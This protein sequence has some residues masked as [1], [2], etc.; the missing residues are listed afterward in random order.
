MTGKFKRAPRAAASRQ[1]CAAARH[2]QA[3]TCS[4]A[5]ERMARKECH[6]PASGFALFRNG[7]EACPFRAAPMTHMKEEASCFWRACYFQAVIKRLSEIREFETIWRSCHRDSPRH[8]CCFPE[9]Y[10]KIARC[11]GKKFV[12]E[13]TGRLGKTLRG[14]R[15]PLLLAHRRRPLASVRRDV[16]VELVEEIVRRRAHC[17][18]T[19]PKKVCELFEH[20]FIHEEDIGKSS[21]MVLTRTR[22]ALRRSTLLK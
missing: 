20:R 22:V 12:D 6:F 19:E 10:V 14:E 18:K 2:R 5:C 4:S 3:A 9:K 1:G 21:I 7:E 16:E 8:V 13:W 11:F 15:G 17:R